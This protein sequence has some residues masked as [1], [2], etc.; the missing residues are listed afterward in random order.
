ML[1]LVH[2][3]VFHQQNGIEYVE[4]CLTKLGME[5][6]LL[7][8]VCSVFGIVRALLSGSSVTEVLR[9][10]HVK[11]LSCPAPSEQTL[12]ELLYSYLVHWIGKHLLSE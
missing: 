6:W 1:S 7:R 9:E 5:P 11:Q 4:T 12:A 10:V 2:T 3:Q 8:Q